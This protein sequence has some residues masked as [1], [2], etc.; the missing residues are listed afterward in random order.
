[1]SNEEKK[2]EKKQEKKKEPL[3]QKQENGMILTAENVTAYGLPVEVETMDMGKGAVFLPIGGK[4][5]GRKYT[6][7]KYKWV[8]E[9][10]SA[11]S[12][13]Q[14]EELKKTIEYS[15]GTAAVYVT[16]VV[17]AAIQ[18]KNCGYLNPRGKFCSNCGKPL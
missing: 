1:V 5:E 12:P 13:Q 8:I 14:I 18:C 3:F 4:A 7:V 2:A 6:K 11:L 16:N 10:G 17:A 15:S 9:S